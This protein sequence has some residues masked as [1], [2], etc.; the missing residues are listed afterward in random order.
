MSWTPCPFITLWLSA[1]RDVDYRFLIVNLILNYLQFVSA[2][3]FFPSFVRLN[4]QS[5][6]NDVA[7]SDSRHLLTVLRFLLELSVSSLRYFRAHIN[8]ACFNLSF[9]AKLLVA[10][11]ALVYIATK[12]GAA[13]KYLWTARCS[14]FTKISSTS[15]HPHP[16]DRALLAMQRLLSQFVP[17]VLHFVPFWNMKTHFSAQS[18]MKL[19]CLPNS[20]NPVLIL[21]STVVCDICEPL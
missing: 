8:L 19:C 21:Q 18:S 6:L 15:C 3:P 5:T 17:G 2:R 20:M 4:M 10:I 14:N 9:C 11:W 16:R 1:L 12:E 13:I 7:I